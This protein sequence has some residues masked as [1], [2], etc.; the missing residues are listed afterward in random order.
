MEQAARCGFEHHGHPVYGTLRSGWAE[1]PSFPQSLFVN[2][3]KCATFLP[4]PCSMNLGSTTQQ[5]D[6]NYA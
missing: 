6:N 3:T 4:V 5:L 1:Y 2:G